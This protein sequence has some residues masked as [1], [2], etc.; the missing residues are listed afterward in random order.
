M[1]WPMAPEPDLCRY[2]IY[3]VPRADTALAQFG[4]DLI[5]VDALT[6]ASKDMPEDLPFESPL[7]KRWTEEP[8]RYGFHATLKAPMSLA[9]SKEERDL[10]AAAEMFARTRRP[11][12]VAR[13]DVALLG[14]FVALVPAVSADAVNSLAADCVIA[15]EPFRAPLSAADRARRLSKPLSARQTQYLDSFGYPFVMEEYRFHMTLTGSLPTEV[16]PRVA[17]FLASRYA[18]LAPGVDIDAIAILRQTR[19][20][21]PFRPWR[22]FPFGGG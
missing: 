19:R 1:K 6:G 11:F 7:W 17:A 20:S 21:E 4:A 9:D 16:R 8:R 2:A 3:F 15:F 5:G 10:A 12:A 18:T 13:L 22:R 14:G